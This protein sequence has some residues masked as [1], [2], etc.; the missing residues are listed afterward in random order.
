M[1]K[2]FSPSALGINGRQSELIELALTYGFTGMDVDMHDML[3]RSQRTDTEDASKY[4]RAANI[5]IGGF[6]L[7]VDLDS[8]EETFTSQVGSLHPLADLAKELEATRCFIRLPAAT[9]RL[10]YHEYFEAQGARL[11]Q[12]A[13]VL[14]PRGIQLGVGFSAGKELEKGKEFPFVRNVEG[15]LAL[16]QS[17]K[18]DGVGCLIDTWDW[19]VG[20]GAMDQLSELK[21]EQIVGV[22]LGSVPDD[23]DPTKAE[24]SDR[25]LPEKEGALNHVELV[26]HLASIGFSGPLSPSAAGKSYKGQ[27]RESIVQRA[28]QAVDLISSEADL[29][30]APLPM[31]LIEDIPYEPDA[32]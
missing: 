27:T 26:K 19:V 2:N 5:L 28:Q 31:E 4:L 7:G 22:R 10:P 9:D 17:V 13:E 25:V 30:V 16:I 29:P 12:I 24:T 1:L 15:F 23:V 21:C 18:A 3:R 14:S 8:D 6:N 11:T 20:D 32:V